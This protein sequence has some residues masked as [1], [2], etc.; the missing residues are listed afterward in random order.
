LFEKIISHSG[1]GRDML[2]RAVQSALAGLATYHLMSRLNPQE[3]FLAILSAVLIIQP[4]VGG[5]MGAAW[6][7]LQATV[8]GSLI[9][10]G[11]VTLLP[12]IW[13]TSAAL[14]LSLLVVGGIAG[15]RPDW[16]YGAVAAV[17]I[18]LA[19][20][21][22][23][24]ET[25]GMRA[26]AIG[27]GAATGVIVSLLIWPDRAESRFDRHFRNALRAT[28]TRLDD[29]LEAA[30]KKGREAAPPDHV[31]DY[32]K[33][34]QQAQEALGAVKLVDCADMQRRLDALRRL[35]NSV[36]ILDRAAETTV[37][38]VSENCGLKDE[39]ST[40]RRETCDM[41]RTL[42]EGKEGSVQRTQQIDEALRRLR[43]VLAEDD[44]RSELHQ[45]R[46]ALAFGLHEVRKALAE[47][48]GLCERQD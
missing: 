25:A 10:L 6:T 9:S 18:A 5:T 2:R 24:P 3:A 1:G 22:E 17:A 21:A 38:P 32:H 44:P 14:A 42:A 34:L 45:N 7:R 31:S 43:A 33:A 28:A 35:Y 46:T 16:A 37:A 4:S 8:T 40:L 29:A 47:L 20:E 30:T 12:D 13:G 11:C 23:A 48:I 19:P 15:L 41:L 39:V 36:I 27:L 26:L